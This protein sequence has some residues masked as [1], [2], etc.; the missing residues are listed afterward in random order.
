MN[1]RSHIPSPAPS[2]ASTRRSV[3]RHRLAVLGISALAATTAMA[4]CAP[5][6]SQ[7]KGSRQSVV[8]Q[9]TR[10]STT[11]RPPATAK[12]TASTT[13]APTPTTAAPPTVP[14]PVSAGVTLRPID[15]G[16]G[17]FAKWANSFPTDPG[18]FPVGIWAETLGDPSFIGQYKAMGVNTFTNLWDGPTKDQMDQ[19]KAN[20][21]YAVGQANP[22]ALS[23]T[24]NA[25]Y[26]NAQ[27][28]YYYQDEGDGGDVCGY[29]LTWLAAL[30]KVGSDGRT[31]ASSLATMA[32][33]IR[34]KDA[35]R[36]VYGQFTKP[37]ALNSG[38]TDTQ[39][40]AYV[41]GVDIV[42][43]DWYTLTDSYNP[44][45]V[46]QQGDAMRHVR[47]LTNF[48]K[49][50]WGFI[51]TSHVFPEA[52]YRPTAADVN[53]EVW[54]AIIGGARGI[55]YFNHS[56]K[57]GLDT[58]R[59]LLDDRYTDI[60][61]QVSTT[62]A[63]IRELAPV[64]NAPYADGLASIAAGNANLMVKAQN[65]SYYLF[66]TPRQKGAQSVTINVGGAGASTASVLYE[67]RSLPLSNGQLVDTFANQNTVHIYKITPGS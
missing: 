4:A 31:T 52:T 20:G 34:A 51:E 2:P 26:G 67:N 53:A 9:P 49:P 32:N 11:L 18:F 29:Q 30:C 36:P 66:V 42:S 35:T 1:P 62:N 7:T 12:A 24:F 27:A 55:Q 10:S 39:A 56:F 40:A 50:V 58:Q 64:L 6:V 3:P 59:V 14:P 43:Y 54:N 17:Y 23:S 28:G 45:T 48:T 65:G 38:L 25:S 13:V 60:R 5:R 8:T 19:L 33:A 47:Q 46:W 61:N 63:R 37:V 44:G 16:P 15:G 41:N 57:A 22:F 21:M